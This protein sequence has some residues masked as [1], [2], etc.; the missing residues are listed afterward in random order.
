[1]NIYVGNISYTMTEKDLED[2]FAEYGV[3]ENARI[4]NNKETGRSKGFGFIEMPNQEEAEKAINQLNEKEISGRN[5][6]VNEAR[7]KDDRPR[8]DQSYW[9]FI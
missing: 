5:I 2:L 9:H 1:M 6:R 4:I 8:R 7:P 3:V